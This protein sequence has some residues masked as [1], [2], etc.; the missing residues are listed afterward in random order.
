MRNRNWPVI[1]RL[2]PKR[3]VRRKGG[4]L[5]ILQQRCKCQNNTQYSAVAIEDGLKL[6]IV[7]SSAVVSVLS[8]RKRGT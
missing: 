6:G 8:S 5:R 7:R 4:Q 1:S 3:I 2:I